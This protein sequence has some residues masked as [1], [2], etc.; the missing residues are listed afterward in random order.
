MYPHVFPP[1]WIKG[2]L[3]D[4]FH[5]SLF[6]WIDGNWNWGGGQCGLKRLEERTYGGGEI[7]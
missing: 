3:Y 7:F 2:I 5:T 4:L 6:C 1:H